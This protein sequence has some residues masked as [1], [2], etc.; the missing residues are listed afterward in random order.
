M[1]PLTSHPFFLF[2]LD[3]KTSV[4]NPINGTS[5]ETKNFSVIDVVNSTMSTVESLNSSTISPVDIA[6]SSSP[7]PIVETNSTLYNSGSER[8]TR[9]TIQRGCK[10]VDFLEGMLL[11]SR[12]TNDTDASEKVYA[13]LCSTKLCNT[14]DGRKCIL[15]SACDITNLTD[16]FIH[17]FSSRRFNVLCV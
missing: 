10:S 15:N 12:T 4:I 11:S 13:Q 5:N 6:I 9:V 3:S 17:F 8:S 14:G 2:P 1:Q 16:F 7:A